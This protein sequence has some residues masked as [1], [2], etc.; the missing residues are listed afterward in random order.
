MGNESSW[1][2]ASWQQRA[3]DALRADFDTSPQLKRD[4]IEFLFE[5]GLYKAETLQYEAA[6]TRFNGCL[7]PGSQYFFKFSEVR[8]LSR[9]FERFES[10]RLWAEDTG[11]EPLRR[12]ASEA[13]V[14]LLLERICAAL[15]SNKDTVQV[16][17]RDLSCLGIKVPVHLHPAIASG[18]GGGSFD[19]GGF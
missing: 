1:L 10:M 18:D 8:A 2:D 16:A 4:M 9:R 3:V 14:Q 12:M 15:E 11:H 6:K 5:V 17:L 13:R 19:K 7:N